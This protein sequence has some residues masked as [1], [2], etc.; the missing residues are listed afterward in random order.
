MARITNFV[1][2][3]VMAVA[4]MVLMSPRLSLADIAFTASA[5]LAT[6][7]ARHAYHRV[8]R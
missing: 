5:V 7:A 3:V 2:S 4:L 1:L 6:S 8:L